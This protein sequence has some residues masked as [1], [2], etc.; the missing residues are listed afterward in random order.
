MGTIQGVAMREWLFGLAPAA[1][2]IY[3]AFNPAQGRQLLT[4]AMAYLH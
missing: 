2:L 3:L 1:L 4:V